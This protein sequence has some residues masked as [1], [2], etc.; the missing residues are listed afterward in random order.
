MDIRFDDSRYTL[1]ELK[2]LIRIHTAYQHANKGDHYLEIN[3]VEKALVEYGLASEF[4][5]ENS[6]IVLSNV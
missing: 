4:F 2:R 6:M 1:K 3:E 5:P